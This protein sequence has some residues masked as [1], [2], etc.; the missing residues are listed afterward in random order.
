MV[1]AWTPS[2]AMTASALGDHPLAGE[3]GTTVLIVD[4]RVEPQRG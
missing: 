3:P 1:K 4:G 2:S